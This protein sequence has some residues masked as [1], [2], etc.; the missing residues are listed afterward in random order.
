MDYESLGR[1]ES[2]AEVGEL[3]RGGRLSPGTL[4]YVGSP[5]ATDS[6][7]M[8][9]AAKHEHVVL[10][11]DLDFGA[12]LAAIRGSR[13]S[14]VQIRSD[15]LTPDSIGGSV[16]AA[17]HQASQELSVGALVSVD[18]GRSRLRILPLK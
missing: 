10:T 18:A 9:W 3:P 12:I 2:I 14:V 13:P 4:E 6:E 11:A 17:L 5:D 1:H 16:V 15:L 8:A 7:L